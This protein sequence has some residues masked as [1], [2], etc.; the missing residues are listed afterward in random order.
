MFLL[1]SI[2][3]QARWLEKDQ[4]KIHHIQIVHEIIHILDFCSV[5]ILNVDKAITY[6][7]VTGRKVLNGCGATSNKLIKGYNP[8][9]FILSTGF[10]LAYL[11]L[12]L[13]FK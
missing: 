12:D 6:K 4:S 8:N 13:F 5:E 11:H 10:I 1:R 9:F 7:F 2:I 3:S